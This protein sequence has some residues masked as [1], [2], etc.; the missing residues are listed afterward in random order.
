MEVLKRM[1][2]IVTCFKVACHYT[3]KNKAA[4]NYGRDDNEG[5]KYRFVRFFL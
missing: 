2:A 4:D 3:H 5:Y 1:A